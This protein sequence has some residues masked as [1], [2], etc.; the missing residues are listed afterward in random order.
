MM[1]YYNCL[2]KLGPKN[3]LKTM[4]PKTLGYI[5]DFVFFPETFVFG[6][7]MEKHV[8]VSFGASNCTISSPKC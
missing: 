2:G 5:S 6:H 1:N 7:F 8:Y 3:L 4:L